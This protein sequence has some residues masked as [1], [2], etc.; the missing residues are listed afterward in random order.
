MPE[1]TPAGLFEGILL[2]RGD[3]GY[4]RARADAVW[5]GLTPERFPEAILQ[6]A[7]ERD[8]PLALAWA[9]AAG[10]RVSTR[11]GGHNWSGSQLRDGGLLIDLSRLRHCSVDPVS[12]TAEVGPA[13]TGTDLVEALAPHD[14]A[15]PVGHCPSV[16]VGGFLLS[17]GL[18]WN[19][20]VWGP[21]CADVLEIR[22]VTADGRTVICSETENADL[23][24]AARGAGRAS[25]PSSP[26]SGSACTR[27]PPQSR[28]P[29]SPS[30]WPTSSV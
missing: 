5:N 21:A 14:L 9:R 23:F 2:R 15:F 22:A 11:S 29:A 10:L 8:I 3:L 27:T 16:A 28:P 30:R 26:D 18:G 13:V 17:G 25:S 7:A 12:A 19:S 24:W 6:A 4:D 20:R 1:R